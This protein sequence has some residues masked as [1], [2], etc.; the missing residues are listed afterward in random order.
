MKKI[1]LSKLLFCYNRCRLFYEGEYM[2]KKLLRVIEKIM[3]ADRF[4]IAV[5]AVVFNCIVYY[6]ARII[7][8]GWEHHI[9]TSNLD[10]MI[11]FI[12]ESLTIY[13]GCYI[14]WI[15]NYIMIAKLDKEW[16]YQF[17]FADF[18]SRIVCFVIFL[19]YP[20][21]N[22]RPELQGSGI[23]NTGMSLLYQVDAA[24]NLFPSIHCMVSWFCFIGIRG[25]KKVPK[26]YQCVSC[27][28]AV[29]VFISTLTTKQHV[30][31]DIIGGVAIAELTFFFAKHTGYYRKYIKAWNWIALKLFGTKEET[32]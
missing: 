24:D 13:L 17:F 29:L 9:L 14:F 4:L 5:F 18:I 27:G 11:P 7:A 3:P 28:L 31:I 6:L 30:I 8:G 19:L 1:L 10:E 25:K 12:P 26:W 32:T 2:R 23:W 21:T 22:I 16:A 20:T 15:I